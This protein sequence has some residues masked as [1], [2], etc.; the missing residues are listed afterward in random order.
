MDPNEDVKQVLVRASADQIKDFRD[1]SLIWKDVKREMAI[2]SRMFQREV[3]EVIDDVVAGQREA[4][5][6]LTHLGSIHGRVKA[7]EY[8]LSLPDIFLQT[9]EMQKEARKRAQDAQKTKE[10]EVS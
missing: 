10:E 9:L 8:M 5:S 3:M 7:V 1:N 4:G 6:A 2:W